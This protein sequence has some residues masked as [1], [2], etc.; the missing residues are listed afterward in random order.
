MM[1]GTPMKTVIVA[2]TPAEAAK[3]IDNFFDIPFPDGWTGTAHALDFFL[4]ATQPVKP[5]RS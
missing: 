4:E 3:A 2:R 5:D 1:D